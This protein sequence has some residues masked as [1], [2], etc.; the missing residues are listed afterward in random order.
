MKDCVKEVRLLRE[1]PEYARDQHGNLAEQM[2]PLGP[3]RGIDTARYDRGR[4]P[5]G[6]GRSGHDGEPRRS[7]ARMRAPPAMA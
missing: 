6:R 7:I 4:R 3:L 1:L 5:S 2:R